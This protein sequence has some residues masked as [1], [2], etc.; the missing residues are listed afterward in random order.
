MHG[1]GSA[2]W[3]FQASDPQRSNAPGIRLSLRVGS[4]CGVCFV[5]HLA[6]GKAIRCGVLRASIRIANQRISRFSVKR[7]SIIVA[8]I[9]RHYAEAVAAGAAI[10]IAIK[11]EDYGGRGYSCR[12][13][14]GHIWNFVSYD[15]WVM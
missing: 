8:E 12:D 15:P 14:E 9:D 3:L 13:P 11:D 1:A 2:A 5:G 7:P 10:V 4:K 6:N